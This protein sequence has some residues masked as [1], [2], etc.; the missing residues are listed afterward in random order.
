MAGR[1]ITGW[2]SERSQGLGDHAVAVG[3]FHGAVEAELGQKATR[4]WLMETFGF[5][6]MFVVGAIVTL[7]L[8]LGFYMLF[9]WSSS[10]L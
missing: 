4:D 10:V 2:L 5:P 1:D 3:Q 8:P 7:L 9:A 6:L